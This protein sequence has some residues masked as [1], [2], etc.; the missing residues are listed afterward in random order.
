MKTELLRF[1]G[2][3]AGHP[4][5]V[6]VFAAAL[7]LAFLAFCLGRVSRDKEVAMTQGRLIEPRPGMSAQ[8]PYR[9]RSRGKD[10]R[11]KKRAR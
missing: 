2:T 1:F 6:G 11:F 7:V 3:I 9:S 4:R 8:K 5:E 10:G